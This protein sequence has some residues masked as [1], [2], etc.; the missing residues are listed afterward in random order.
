MQH[1]IEDCKAKE[2]RGARGR[3]RCNWLTSLLP[4][5]IATYIKAYFGRTIFSS[6]SMGTI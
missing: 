1:D 6:S 2:R 5:A 3:R 4:F